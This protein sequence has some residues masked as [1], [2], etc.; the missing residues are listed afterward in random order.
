[1]QKTKIILI[2][3]FVGF[4]FTVLF[5]VKDDNVL[6]HVG[7]MENMVLPAWNLCVFN[8]VF[9]FFSTFFNVVYCHYYNA[10]HVKIG[11]D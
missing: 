2:H 8:T 9:L 10:R 6:N 5:N 4:L 1:M 7:R 3:R 11:F